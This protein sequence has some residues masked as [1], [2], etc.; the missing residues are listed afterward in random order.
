MDVT[1]ILGFFYHFFQEEDKSA[2]SVLKI[3]AYEACR[4][5]RDKL[6]KEEAEEKF[7]SLLKGVLQADWNSGAF[8]SI[9]NSYYVTLGDSN[10]SPGS[11]MPAF[12]RKLGQL[13]PTDW[14]PLVAKGIISFERENRDLS[15]AVLVKETL[16]LVAACDRVLSKPGGSMLM[17]GKSGVGR[18]CAVSIVSALHQA[19]LINLKMGN[20]ILEFIVPKWF[21]KKNSWSNFQTKFVNP[22]IIQKI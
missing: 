3:W 21:D 20:F 10:Y 11:G 15:D 16:D 8:E 5:F 13:S 12:G 19:K 18:R 9:I 17:C 6:A 2:K 14:E 1:N 7:D 4:L 22:L